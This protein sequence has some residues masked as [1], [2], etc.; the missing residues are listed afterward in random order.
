MKPQ[1]L[2]PF[3]FSATAERALAWAA[4][5]QRSTGAGPIRMVHAITSRP[6]GTA[7][8]TLDLLLPDETEILALEASMRVAAERVG[9]RA[10]GGVTIAS[11]AVGDILLDVAKQNGID[12]I[13]M[14]T[15]GRTGVKRLVLGSVAE[16]V[17]RHAGCPVVVVHHG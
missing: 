1:I 2:V 3:D 5:L 8:I 15:H 16:H 6:P 13:V 17:V 10:D 11:S 7:D 14:G 4:D 12:L 9:A